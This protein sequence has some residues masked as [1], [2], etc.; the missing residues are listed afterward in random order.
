MK[1]LIAPFPALLFLLAVLFSGCII[2]QRYPMAKSRLT[3][4]DKRQLTFY[5][6]DAARP[7]SRVWYISEADFQE[8]KMNGFL[9]RLDE[10]EAQEVATVSNSRDARYSKNEVLMYVA[11]KYAL[12]LGDTTTITLHYNQVEKIEVHEVNHSKSLILSFLCLFM[13]LSLL[14]AIGA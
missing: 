12:A 1:T 9:I 5:L 10:A 8:D 3:K 2:Y 13:P 6:L 4:I 14:A 11:P 7:M